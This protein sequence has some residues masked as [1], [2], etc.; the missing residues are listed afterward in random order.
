[1]SL[2]FIL[3]KYLAFFALSGVSML[4]SYNMFSQLS[5]VPVESFL[6]SVVAIAIEA[7]KIFSLV[8]GNTLWRL[9]LTQQAIRSWVM[10]G[11]L[12]ILAVLASYGY[13]LTVV[14]RGIQ[15]AEQ[16]VTQV[17]IEANRQELE[18]VEEQIENLGQQIDTAVQRQQDTPFDFVT[19]WQN[20]TEQINRLEEQRASFI[21][22]RLELNTEYANLRTQLAQEQATATSTTTMFRLMAESFGVPE[23]LLML[24]LLLAIAILIELGIVSTSPGIPIDKNH[25]K[26]IVDEFAHNIDVDQLRAQQELERLQHQKELHKLYEEAGVPEPAKTPIYNDEKKQPADKDNPDPWPPEEPN[27]NLRKLIAD[28]TDPTLPEEPEGGLAAYTPEQP[29]E[30][31]SFFGA[32]KTV[33]FNRNKNDEPVSRTQTGEREAVHSKPEELRPVP[34]THGTEITHPDSD[35]IGTND[36][37][38]SVEYTDSGDEVGQVFPHGTSRVEYDD[39]P[40][41]KLP[42]HPELPKEEHDDVVEK[43]N[44]TYQIPER[45]LT[46]K[47]KDIEVKDTENEAS[48]EEPKEE[49]TEVPKRTPRRARKVEK[50]EEKPAEREQPEEPKASTDDPRPR[51]RVRQD[52]PREEVSEEASNQSDVQKDTVEELH[53]GKRTPQR[54]TA[55]PEA[56]GETKTFRFGKTTDEVK[57]LFVKF[58]NKLFSENGEDFLQDPAVAARD[59]GIKPKLGT[60]FIKRLTE[61]KGSNGMPLVEQRDDGLYYPNYTKEYIISYSTKEINTQGRAV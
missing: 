31:P 2:I 36:S 6:L 16:S 43:E 35:H 27:E 13:T 4:L 19:A 28:P 23:M 39:I 24:V 51:P 21:E 8:R 32:L 53:V 52:S 20:I 5:T 7:L 1:M 60:V 26:H 46:R 56:V 59:S 33:L 44:N 58:I 15:A 9:H 50:A 55:K 3:M 47:P 38:E 34:P 54:Q 30:E 42:E 41:R 25:M 12:A 61:L 40:V 17:Q 22:R 10:Y 18:I 14:D 49:P 29:E 37:G 45:K 11:L 57:A 48:I